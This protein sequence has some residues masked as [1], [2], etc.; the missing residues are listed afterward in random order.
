MKWIT[1]LNIGVDHLVFDFRGQHIWAKFKDQ[2]FSHVSFVT[3]EVYAKA[4]V[5]VKASCVF[6]TNN[7]IN[8]LGN[9]FPSHELM[10]VLSM[11]GMVYP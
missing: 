1:N 10:D 2:A 6:A 7:L 11:V 3:R 8:E 4:I 5:E 9:Q